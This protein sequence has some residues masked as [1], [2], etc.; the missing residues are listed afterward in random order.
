M[1]ALRAW[2]GTDDCAD[3]AS[4]LQQQAE[5]EWD[6][7]PDY[8]AGN[9]S[10]MISEAA[11]HQRQVDAAFR[12]LDDEFITAKRT[13]DG[14]TGE[15]QAAERVILKRYFDE[16]GTISVF[17]NEYWRTAGAMLLDPENGLHVAVPRFLQS[18]V[19]RADKVRA[20][21]I[22]T[23]E[24][25]PDV[26]NPTQLPRGGVRVL[27]RHRRP[28][29][30]IDLVTRQTQPP[31]PTVFSQ[32]IAPVANTLPPAP[33]NSWIGTPLGQGGMGSTRVFSERD[34]AGQVVRRIVVKDTTP[35]LTNEMFEMPTY[36][37]GDLSQAGW[38]TSTVPMEYHIQKIAGD[39]PQIVNSVRV[40]GAPQINWAQR[41]F[42][43]YMEFA[44]EGDLEQLQD[45]HWVHN[46]PVPERFLWVLLSALLDAC[47]VLK[48]G[49]LDN[50][51]TP[52]SEIVH[53]DLKPPNVFL[54]S[55]G[56]TF[57]QW[58]TIK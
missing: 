55:A 54:S 46:E 35:A 33:G 25:E 37:Y 50:P 15:L 43:I 27:G 26:T 4:G 51:S 53:C 20:L 21:W 41:A 49:G 28:K 10:R 36:W 31:A 40:I 39:A 14:M 29:A 1:T 18:M 9:F 19:Y 45:R 23:R 44:P 16:C 47:M 7:F 42:R 13:W 5:N 8:M 38:K 17:T 57:P 11:S 34:A 56:N 22:D 3:V 12:R 2:L 6:A 30:T 32:P 58:P 52:W 24:R 48:Q